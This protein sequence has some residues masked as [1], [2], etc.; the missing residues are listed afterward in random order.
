MFVDDLN[1][2][3]T[4]SWILFLLEEKKMEELVEIVDTSQSRFNMLMQV[5]VTL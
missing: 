5:V 4:F 3:I 2:N 1:I